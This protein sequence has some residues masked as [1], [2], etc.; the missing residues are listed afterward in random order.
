[1]KTARTHGP[2]ALAAPEPTPSSCQEA[3]Q[4]TYS[5]NGRSS[6]WSSVGER[7]AGSPVTGQRCGSAGDT[8][9][10]VTV[11]GGPAD[12]RTEPPMPQLLRSGR[13]RGAALQR[14]GE[15]PSQEEPRAR[16]LAA[17]SQRHRG[18]LS[19]LCFWTFSLTSQ[20]LSVRTPP[21]ADGATAPFGKLELAPRC[22]PS[23]RLP[24]PQSSR[25]APQELCL[26]SSRRPPAPASLAE[27]AAGL[28]RLRGFRTDSPS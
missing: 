4:G 26:L 28:A 1:M 13:S 2:S 8:G 19:C 6:T 22:A 25:A 10:D 16:G 5:S 7:P 27:V 11:R 14:R 15:D 21:A 12:A 9:R 18:S 3:A 23:R 17:G 20:R 24:F